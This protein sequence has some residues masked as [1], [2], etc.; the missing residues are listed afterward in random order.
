[1]RESMHWRPCLALLLAACVAFAAH[2]GDDPAGAATARKVVKISAGAQAFVAEGD[3]FRR[4]GPAQGKLVLPAVV[5]AVSPRGYVQ[6][7]GSSGPLWL[8]ELD[9]DIEP[10]Q[11]A[12]KA[13]CTLAVSSDAS[14]RVAASRGAG[15]GCSH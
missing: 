11:T 4:D 15:E 12:A 6:V 13:D 10:R 1:M 8:D 7:Q 5:L 14:T 9:V 3:G 2:A